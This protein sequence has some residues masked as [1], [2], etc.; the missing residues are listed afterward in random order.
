MKKELYDVIEDLDS[1]RLE[2][3]YQFKANKAFLDSV[4][5]NDRERLNTIDG[6]EYTQKGLLNH[7]EKIS[8]ELTELMK[9]K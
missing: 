4:L 1:L 8:N 9:C 5:Q 7:F 2:L 3:F 6:M